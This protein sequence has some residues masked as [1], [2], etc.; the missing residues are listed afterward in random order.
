MNL[1]VVIPVYKAERF[2]VSSVE[3]AL[4][5]PETR[6]VIL[7]ED[8]SP[9]GCMELCRR[10]SESD[11]RVRIVQHPNGEN[12][13]AGPSRNLGVREARYDYVAFLDADD[14]YLPGRFKTASMLLEPPSDVD[15][16]YEAVG[17]EFESAEAEKRYRA[18]HT[19]DIATVGARVAPHLL[20]DHLTTSG[21]G[22]IH[23]DGLVVK[24]SSLLRV[25]LFP[26]LRLHQDTVLVLKLAA[27]CRL[28]PGEI[29]RP[30][31]IRRL[32]S[33]NRITNLSV[34]FSA[35]RL[36]AARNL[37]QWACVERIPR[38]IRAVLRCRYYGATYRARKISRSWTSAAYF[39][40]LYRL[41]FCR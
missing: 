26:D 2:L 9:D 38:R 31:A 15:G 39:Y 25:G 11:R 32:H 29:Q 13:G 21:S 30:V 35:T 5:Q 20:F 14:Y 3:S 40:L 36:M 19:S 7:V 22:Y 37:Y 10:L 34:D 33:N 8:G 28:L 23:L 18:T 12:R 41:T 17:A 1:S 6:E 4:S 27:M 16:V 24:R